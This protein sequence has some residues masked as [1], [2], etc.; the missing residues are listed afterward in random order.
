MI[1][2]FLEAVFEAP[3]DIQHLLDSYLMSFL[4]DLRKTGCFQFV[5]VHRSGA[6]RFRVRCGA[7]GRE[8]LDRY[9]KDFF[10]QFKQRFDQTFDG[11]IKVVREVWETM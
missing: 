7:A 8:S 5:E 1:M 9:A 4:M 11:R 10:P 2:I 6:S 3:P